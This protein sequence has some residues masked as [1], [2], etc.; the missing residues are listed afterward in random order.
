MTKLTARDLDS[1]YGDLRNDGMSA[2]TIRNHHGM[3]SAA[4]SLALRWDLVAENVA[5]KARPPSIPPGAVKSPSAA[6]VERIITLANQ[7]DPRLA[8]L[9][10]LA[11]LTGMRRGELCGLRWSDIDFDERSIMVSRSVVSITGGVIEKATKTNRERRI[12]IDELGEYILRL[13][14]D[15]VLRWAD[16]AEIQLHP[17]AF[18]FSND[19]DG[20]R[21]FRPDTIT[22]RFIDLCKALGIR[23]VRFHDLRHFTATQLIAAGID[24]RTVAGRLGHQDANMTLKTYAHVL[25]GRDRA[26]ADVMG[27]VLWSIPQAPQKADQS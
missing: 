13:H 3:I 10:F 6:D 4:L 20:S 2:K 23:G 21:P 17:Q 1:F 22:S 5:K 12:S 15:R 7:R 14:E 11:A 27:A 18:V 8:T 16:E 9:I 24:V 26:A 19:L 25:E